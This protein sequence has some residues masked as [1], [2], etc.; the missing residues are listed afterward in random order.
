MGKN[1]KNRDSE[2]NADP[3]PP[4]LVKVSESPSV[5]V[6][7][8]STAAGVTASTKQADMLSVLTGISGILQKGFDSLNSKVKLVADGIDNMEDNM[9]KRFDDLMVEP[10]PS[11]NESEGDVANDDVAAQ[12]LLPTDKG[13]KR[14]RQDDHDLSDGE[15]EEVSEVLTEASNAL[16]EDDS[17]GPPIKESVAAFVKKAFAKPL[18]G[19]NVKRFKD[20]FPAP[21]NVDCLDVPRANEPIYLKLSATAKNKDK[22]IQDN[23]AIFL[24][25][26]CALVKVTD[27]LSEHEKEGEW[28]KDTMKMST[29]AITLAATLKKD[30]LKARRDDIKPSIPDDFKR[31]ASADVPLDAKN[32]FGDD[33]EGA[34]KSV[35]NTNKIA[36]KM[37]APKVKTQGYN[38]SYKNKK[39]RRFYSNNNKNNRNNNH[40]NNSGRNDNKNNKK[41]YGDKKDFRGR[42]A[43]N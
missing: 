22:A 34:I 43:R 19:D 40:N 25:V 36:K 17:V 41:D 32:L 35:E 18:K 9:V 11:D 7:N 33:L 6:S 23:Q 29:E 21:S 31:L 38:N 13:T 8:P 27:V 24:R 37:D 3:P 14:K 16:D 42:G 12:P 4:K 30:W 20:K 1:A 10:P 15:I 28:V 5:A 2:G 26:V 39:K